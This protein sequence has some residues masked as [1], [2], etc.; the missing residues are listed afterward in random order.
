MAQEDADIHPRDIFSLVMRNANSPIRGWTFKWEKTG[1]TIWSEIDFD[2]YI[3]TAHKKGHPDAYFHVSIASGVEN[4][5]EQ[6]LYEVRVKQ[7]K[8]PGEDWNHNFWWD[9]GEWKGERG[10]SDHWVPLPD[11]PKEGVCTHGGWSMMPVTK[12][13]CFNPKT[14][15][16]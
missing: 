10:R 4:S 15:E 11:N 7:I 9:E 16:Q 14:E 6:S 8:T 2:E 12:D 1:L 5:T 13:G 3:I